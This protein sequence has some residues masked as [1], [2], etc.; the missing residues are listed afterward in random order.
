MLRPSRV[1]FM[2]TPEFAVPCVEALAAH[3][4]CT[5]VAVVCQPDKPAGRSREPVPPPTKLAAQRLGV[6]VLQPLKLRSGDFPDALAA[7]RPDLIVVTAYGRILPTS[8]LTLPRLGCVNLHASLLPRWRGAA[9]IQWAVRS[10]DRETGA[11]LMQ[12]DAGLDTGPV[13]ARTILPIGPLETAADLHDRLSLASAALLSEQLDAV[14]AGALAPVPQPESGVTLARIL[15]REDGRVDFTAAAESVVNHIRGFHPWP[16]ASTQ[17]SG[18]QLK[19]FPPAVRVSEPVS[20]ALGA[21]PGTILAA[22]AQGLVI[23]CGDGAVRVTELQPEGR[24]RMPIADLLRGFSLPVGA[25]LG[26]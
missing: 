6:P 12:M 7:L 18:L 22:E 8:V 23:A 5:L 16:G 4:S 13:L 15:T 19:L 14:I 1:V 26:A 21:T 17:L 10:G 20:G 3:P 9:P 2:G 25:R 24:R 11:C